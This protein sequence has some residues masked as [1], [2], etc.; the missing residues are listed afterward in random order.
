MRNRHAFAFAVAAATLV[1]AGA[2]AGQIRNV[3][4]VTQIQ[5]A[6]FYRT[7]I[8]ISNGSST[9]ST[10]VLM[11]FS[12]R[13][14]AD[15]S[16]QLSFLPLTA[17]VHGHLAGKGNGAFELGPH[18]VRFYDDIVQAFKNAG[19]IRAADVGLGLFGTLLVTFL[20][21]DNPGG[22]GARRTNV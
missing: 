18:Q 21:L 6:A 2:E 19:G 17:E 8:T 5:G 10:P 20:N 12:Y 14:P 9:I 15:G 16:W 22:S 7:S 11:R 4:V 3:P 1:C 13:S